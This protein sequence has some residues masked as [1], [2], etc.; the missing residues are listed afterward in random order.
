MHKK[1]V[2]E[3]QYLFI[4]SSLDGSIEFL[5]EPELWLG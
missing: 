5:R 1:K 4:G 2:K 3:I